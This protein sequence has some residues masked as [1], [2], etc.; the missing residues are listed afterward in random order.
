VVVC[1]IVGSYACSGEDDAR[2]GASVTSISG[3]RPSTSDANPRPA[4]RAVD[5]PQ[6]LVAPTS[7]SKLATTL[8]RVERALRDPGTPPPSIGSLGWEQ[9]LAYRTLSNHDDWE[10]TVLAAL[11]SDVSA[12]VASMVEAGRA[13][14]PLVEPG[15]SLPDWRID[16]PPAPDVLI[17]FYREAEAATGV[18]WPYLAAINFVETRMGRI[19]GTSTAGA[20]GPMQFIASTWDAFGRGGDV[21]DPHDAIL[22]AGRYLASRGAPGDMRRALYSYNNSDDYVDSVQRYADLI[23]AGQE[24]VYDGF[25]HWQVYFATTRGL[26]LLPEG[27]PAVPAVFL[28]HE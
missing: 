18:P 17:G 16:A 8:I 5:R 24:R 3:V 11:P 14:A 10:V 28:P 15:E 2:R 12:V 22:A 27:Y 6:D 9:Q 13:L 4:A 23:A 26:A 20:Q 7:A 21:H 1:V 25:Y 19:H